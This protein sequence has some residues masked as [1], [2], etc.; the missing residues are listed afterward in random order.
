MKESIS[1]SPILTEPS[2]SPF[3]DFNKGPLTVQ[4][5]LMEAVVSMEGSCSWTA[6]SP[7]SLWT[8]LWS[9]PWP[10]GFT[11]A[12]NRQ[13]HLFLERCCQSMRTAMFSLAWKRCRLTLRSDG[14]RDGAR[15]TQ[16]IGIDSTDNEQVDGVGE[17]A[18]DCVR[19]H[20][21]HVSYSL[22]C[23]ACWLAVKG[24]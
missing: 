16:A 3:L 12:G 8:C 13:I 20:L 11:S 19:F 15:V 1:N 24:Q 7:S 9:T 10:V 21:D 17:K 14:L 23:A 18:G 22:P 6:T 5:T 2:N 4:D